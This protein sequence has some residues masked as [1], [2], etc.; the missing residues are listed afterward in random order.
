MPATNADLTIL[1]RVIG[2]GD[3]GQND[4]T[5]FSAGLRVGMGVGL[6]VCLGL[7]LG[8]GILVN[9]Y[10]RTTTTVQSKVSGIRDGLLSYVK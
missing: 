4:L 7:G 3:G 6:G 10:R 9:T 5:W 8:V 1:S 2:D